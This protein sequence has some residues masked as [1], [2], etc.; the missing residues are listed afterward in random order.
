MKLNH[1]FVPAL[2]LIILLIAPF[3]ISANPLLISSNNTVTEQQLP[4]DLLPQQVG[5]FV[6]PLNEGQV[7]TLLITSLHQQA[8]INAQADMVDSMSIVA[9]LK[10]VSDPKSPLG[11]GIYSLIQATDTFW[12]AF[13]KAFSELVPGGGVSG[14]S[15]LMLFLALVIGLSSALEYLCTFRWKRSRQN[16]FEL[17]NFKSNNPSSGYALSHFFVSLF[18]LIIF[19]IISHILIKVFAQN[20]VSDDAANSLFRISRDDQHLLVTTIIE[21]LVVVRFF[22]LLFRLLIAPKPK[23]YAL[24]DGRIN[25]RVLFICM[26]AFTFSYKIGTQ[27]IVLFADNGL[28]TEYMLLSFLFLFGVII[29]PIIYWFVWTQRYAVDCI[30]FGSADSQVVPNSQSPY[31]YAARAMIWP[32]AVT[33]IITLAFLNWQI[34]VLTGNTKGQASIEMAWWLTLTFPIIDLL[35]SSLLLKLVCLNLFQ[36]RGFQLRKQRLILIIRNVV[37]LILLTILII[38]FLEAWGFKAL[39]KLTSSNGINF[40]S[41]TIDIGVTVLLGFIIWEAIQL[42]IEKQLPDEE[43]EDAAEMEGEGGGASASRTE[44]LLPLFR[45]IL[46]ILLLVIVV[47]SVLY[48]LGVQIGPL[49]AG[50]G[51]VGI[52][53]GFGSQKLVQDIISG[54]FFL[55]DDAFRKGEYVQVAGMKG[56]IEKLSVRSMRLRH[57]LGAVQTVPYGEINTVKNLSRDWVIMKLELRLAYDVDIEKVRKII[58]KV[59]QKMLLDPETGPNMLQPL[60][61]QGVM[62]VEES[63]LIFRMKFTA[64]PGEQWVVRR[65][66]YTNV[67]NALAEAGIEFAH[68]EVKVRLPAELEELQ[69]LE[70]R[71][72]I[73]QYNEEKKP[74]KTD[75]TDGVITGAVTAAA[76]TAVVARELELQNKY[77]EDIT[78][79]EQ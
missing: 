78:G 67:R 58:K 34:Q 79:E 45:T 2:L 28:Q 29:N 42:L 6:A 12:A 7:R 64:K 50:A 9:L 70:Y 31:P 47:M 40:L 32:A 15:K 65:V 49:L 52:A 5:D 11:K 23:G 35:V 60:K 71:N 27:V 72:K 59:G 3:K 19:A 13:N 76:M 66:A 17:Q 14:F 16:A 22:T 51:V 75:S 74:I 8:E 33:F 41:S 36:S 43:H 48:S 4:T 25:N 24:I 30:L 44:T 57:H 63:A 53:I 55:I 21:A 68:R 37:R 18:G 26:V 46:L 38:S 62:R 69:K 39:D 54:M 1:I 10:G 73:E 61:S 56:T 20:A 77:D